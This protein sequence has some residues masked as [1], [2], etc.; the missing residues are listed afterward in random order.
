M[1]MQCARGFYENCSKKCNSWLPSD[2][3]EILDKGDKLYMRIVQGQ[4]KYLLLDELPTSIENF[5]LGCGTPVTVSI[6]MASTYLSGPFRDIKHALEHFDKATTEIAFITI[7]GGLPSYSMGLF[8]NKPTGEYYVF[9]P[10]S[11][12]IKMAKQ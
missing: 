12:D 8:N 11:R 3:D 10:H 1:H 2:I 9:D 5:V 4:Y 7:C 6:I